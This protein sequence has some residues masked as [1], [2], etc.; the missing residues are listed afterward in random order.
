MSVRADPIWATVLNRNFYVTSHGKGPHDAAGG[1]VK[2]QA[3]RTVLRGKS[4]IQSAHDLYEYE[5]KI[6]SPQSDIYERRIFRYIQEIP[7]LH[8]NNFKPVDQNRKIHQITSS[9]SAGSRF[10]SFFLNY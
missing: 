1:Y 3:D 8:H 10:V 6:C 4:K 7:R 2:H 9:Q 5:E